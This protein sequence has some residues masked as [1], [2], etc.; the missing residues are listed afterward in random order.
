M[1]WR[2]IDLLPEHLINEDIL[3]RIELRKSGDIIYA[4]GVVSELGDIYAFG[5]A[6]LD[7]GYFRE[8]DGFLSRG[9]YKN[10]WFVDPREILL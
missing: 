6:Y 10:V 7:G 8:L 2:N 9:I 1:N 4:I 5:N 3:L